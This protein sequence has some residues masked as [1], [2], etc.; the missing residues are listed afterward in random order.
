MSRSLDTVSVEAA[1]LVMQKDRDL[2]VWQA[3][4]L[5]AAHAERD[6]LL[7]AFVDAVIHL[8]DWKE[9]GVRRLMQWGV[10]IARIE[11]GK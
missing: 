8:R 6:E 10:L 1:M 5:A 9:P 11:G 2:I 3:E 4:R 7:A